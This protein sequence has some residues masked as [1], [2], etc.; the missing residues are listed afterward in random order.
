MRFCFLFPHPFTN[1]HLTKDTGKIPEVIARQLGWDVEIVCHIQGSLPGRDREIPHVHIHHVSVRGKGRIEPAFLKYL[2]ANA[3][4][5]DVLMLMHFDMNTKLYGVFFKLLNPHGF[6]WNKL[7]LNKEYVQSDE[8]MPRGVWPPRQALSSCLQ[9]RFLRQVD[10]ISTESAGVGELAARLYPKIRSK[11]A[12]VPCGVD[13]VKMPIPDY[14]G[15]RERLILNVASLGTEPKATDILLEAFARSKLWPE[16]QLVLV[17]PVDPG[18]QPWL[19]SFTDRYPDAWRAVRII[20][21][22]ESRQALANWYARSL[23]F[24]MPSRHE[25]WGLALNEAGYYGCACVSTDFSA[26]VDMLDGGQ[27]G[28]LCAKNNVDS[29]ATKLIQ[30]C[31]SD[32]TMDAYG[33]KFQRRII[34]CFTWDNIIR[35][36]HAV[37]STRTK[38]F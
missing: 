19:N 23:V 31:G 13:A 15:P 11:L 5:I 18:F 8:F 2:L 38:R 3:H 27:C 24:C 35:D 1:V 36:W 6:L 33:R 34:E 28:V 25:S 4:R 10:L 7:D 9:H 32:A 16:W 37:F 12:T 14:S 29:L 22:V 20:G 30:V 21:P 17:G 26:A